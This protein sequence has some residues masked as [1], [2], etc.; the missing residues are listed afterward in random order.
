MPSDRRELARRREAAVA[1]Q[2]PVL[3][4]PL[5]RVGELIGQGSRGSAIQLESG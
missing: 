1:G 2:K 5:E 3:D 4:A